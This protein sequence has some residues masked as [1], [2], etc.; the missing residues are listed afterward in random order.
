MFTVNELIFFARIYSIF[1]DDFF[2]LSFTP[3]LVYNFSF[4]YQ[5]AA[6][7]QELTSQ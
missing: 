4:I 1:C 5:R 6:S 2:I 3:C 7:M